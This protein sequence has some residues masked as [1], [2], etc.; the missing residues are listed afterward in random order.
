MSGLLFLRYNERMAARPHYIEVTA[1]PQGTTVANLTLAEQLIDAYVGYQEKYL[2]GQIQG[3]IT[4]LLADEVIVDESPTSVLNQP[5]IVDRYKNCIIEW[6]SGQRA[7]DT[8]VIRASDGDSSSV[9]YTGNTSQAIAVGDI[10]RIWQPLKF[11]RRQDVIVRSTTLSTIYKTIP[12]AVKQAVYAQVEFIIEQGDDYFTGLD[13]EVESENIMSYG[14]SRG[15]NSGQSAAV[16]MVSPKARVLLRGI[17]NIKG[18]LHPE[19]KTWL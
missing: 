19:N 5:G 7:G 8:D 12:D 2:P 16:K 4:S 15:S 18:Q 17:K 9:T 13:S 1:G 3:E 6:L 14:Y 10:F 11:P